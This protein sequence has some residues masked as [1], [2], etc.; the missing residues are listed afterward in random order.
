MSLIV[1]KYFHVGMKA[2]E[3]FRLLR[4]LKDD[5]FEVAEY[6]R[7]GAR[8]WP[9]GE[10]KPYLNEEIRQNIQRRYQNDV[11]GYI[12][13]K[14]YGMIIRLL[15]KKHVSI[16]FRVVDGSGVISDVK[17]SIGASGI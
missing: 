5:G 3:V 1:Q 13:T 15:A 6:R 2:E 7:D 11:S 9:D 14:D 10:L 16:S 12:A 17:G 4:Q 8:I